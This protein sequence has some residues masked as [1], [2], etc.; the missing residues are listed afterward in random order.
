HAVPVSLRELVQQR[1]AGAV[2]VNVRHGQ[3][4][5]RE[6]EG[7]DT[8][9]IGDHDDVAVS[10]DAAREG[11]EEGERSLGRVR[12]ERGSSSGSGGMKKRSMEKATSSTL[13]SASRPIS[14]GNSFYTC[15][16]TNGMERTTPVPLSAAE[17]L[18]RSVLVL[19]VS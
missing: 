13:R 9:G 11:E 18:R 6:D 14:I 19:L 3:I 15:C 5:R 12:E 17:G 1:R 2:L 4:G 8:A 10:P 7:H 16:V